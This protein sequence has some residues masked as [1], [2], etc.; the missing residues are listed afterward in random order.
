[1]ATKTSRYTNL[2]QKARRFFLVLGTLYITL[3]ALGTFP[4]VQRQ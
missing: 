1:M 3:V 2:L 4:F